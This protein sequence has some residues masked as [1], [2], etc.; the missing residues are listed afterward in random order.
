MLPGDVDVYGEEK[1]KLSNAGTSQNGSQASAGISSLHQSL[2]QNITKQPS[3]TPH[4]KCMGRLLW[5]NT[6]EQQF[7]D[8]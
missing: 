3:D 4:A 2:W 6:P 8:N 7:T 1:E 5:V